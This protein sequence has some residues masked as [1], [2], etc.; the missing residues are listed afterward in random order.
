MNIIVALKRFSI[1]ALLLAFSGPSLAQADY[2]NK[3]VR[4]ILPYAPGGTTDMVARAV[5]QQLAVKW[6]QSVIVDAKPGASGLIDTGGASIS[7][8]WLRA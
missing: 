4:I 8:V 7:S 6:G 1:I 5:A 3:L 2:P